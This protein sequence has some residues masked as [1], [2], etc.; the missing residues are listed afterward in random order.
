MACAE[1]NVIVDR[2]EED[3]MAIV[4]INR[5]KVRDALTSPARQSLADAP[6]TL[7]SEAILYVED[8]SLKAGLRLEQNAMPCFSGQMTR[9][10]QCS[11][12]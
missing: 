7:A 4:R 1:D 2:F 9:R 10:R 3:G 11:P 8:H 6:Y 5:P 12:F